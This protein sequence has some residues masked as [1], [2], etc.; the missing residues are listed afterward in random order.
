M[1]ETRARQSRPSSRRPA[2]RTER[3]SD[4]QDAAARASRGLGKLIQRPTEG[5]SAVAPLEEGGWRVSVDVVE[6]ARVPDT[7][8]LLATYE[9]ELSEDGSLRSYRRVHR[10][11]RGAV[12]E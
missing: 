4:A 10:Y 5:C 12:D 3:V 1:A 8:S 11:R 6:V 7:T 2:T 9:V